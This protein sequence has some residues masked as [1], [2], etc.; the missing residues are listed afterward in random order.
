[1]DLNI[2]ILVPVDLNLMLTA[3]IAHIVMLEK[4][5]WKEVFVFLVLLEQYLQDLVN[6][7][8]KIVDQEVKQM[9]HNLVVN[10]AILDTFLM[11]LDNVNS[12]H[13]DPFQQLMVLM[14][15]HFVNVEQD[16]TSNELIVIFVF[17]VNSLLLEFVNHVLL[18]LLPLDSDNANVL[19]VELELKPM[20]HNLDVHFVNLD[21]SLMVLVNVNL[22]LWD[23]FPPI[24]ELMNVLN[25]DVDMN[26]MHNERIANNVFLV[27]SH[28]MV[29]DV[30]LVQ[31][32]LLLLDLDNAN[33]LHVEWELKPIK[34]FLDVLF[35]NLDFSLMV[36]EL[37]K[38]VL[39]ATLLVF[40]DLNIVTPVHVDLNPIVIIRIV[41]TV[42]QEKVQL[43][44]V[45]VFL[46]LL[47]LFHRDSD[48]VDA[49]NAE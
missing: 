34:L 38:N 17:L 21:I 35:V 4:V 7:D 18:A 13:K 39:L 22:V 15:V 3:L 6:V 8:V 27:N 14:N 12:V 48:N 40:M 19:H 5:L 47:E 1:M 11:D 28:L 10:F 24:M 32:T 9:E 42:E 26:P 44:E 20:P 30:N 37:V 29:L 49:K 25:V 23:Q 46:V 43:M 33:V 41:L 16:P 45:F 36:Q 31:T 2:A